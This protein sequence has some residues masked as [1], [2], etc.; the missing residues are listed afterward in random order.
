[1]TQDQTP[2]FVSSVTL[3]SAFEKLCNEP[4]A[5]ITII[6]GRLSCAPT[7]A[8]CDRSDSD[9]WP[10]FEFVNTFWK[11]GNF[12]VSRHA[13]LILALVMLIPVSSSAQ[14]SDV[15]KGLPSAFHCGDR[16]DLKMSPKDKA[17]YWWTNSFNAQM[18]FGAAFNT[19]LDPI[20][21]GQ[22]D[23]YWG[24]GA[25]GFAKRFGTRVAQSMTKGTGQA[26]V[27]ALFKE[28]P[29]FY[30]SRK[31]GFWP[32]FGFALTHTLIVKN[33]AGHEQLSAGRLAGAFSSGFVGMAWTP[34]P[35]NTTDNAL[36]RTGTAMGGVLAGSLWKEF[37]PDI[38]KLA[39]SI[40]RRPP[41]ATPATGATKP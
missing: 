25:E 31:D 9:K 18:L 24:Q 41:K 2:S 34:G 3:A 39:S 32:R 27:G 28:D 5:I 26:L 10:G 19:A 29:R 35:I 14:S 7:A 16:D 12:T 1:M 4:R 30:V 8:R 20:F 6:F 21:N 38:M 40:F 37:Q 23:P 13:C 22:S 17:C 33:D 36:V 15:E 11:A